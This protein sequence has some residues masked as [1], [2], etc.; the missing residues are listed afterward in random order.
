MASTPS[1]SSQLVLLL[2]HATSGSGTRG[3]APLD[4]VLEFE[5]ESAWE[6]FSWPGVCAGKDVGVDSMPVVWHSRRTNTTRFLAADHT[7]MFAGTGPTLDSLSGCSTSPVF[8]ST[9]D[10]TP[11]SYA[12]FQWLQS[13]RVLA[14]GSVAGLLHNEFKGEFAPLGE[15]C[16]R[17]CADRSPVNASGCRGTLRRGSA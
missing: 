2:L 8:L 5:A 3:Q 12:N 13:V 15:Y 9:Y 4:T 10:S 16:S 17:H 14:D 7:H 11:Q 6:T 1:L